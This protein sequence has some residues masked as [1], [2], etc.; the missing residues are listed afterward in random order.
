MTRRDWALAVVLLV[1]AVLVHAAFPRYEWH[2]LGGTAYVRFDRWTGY[3]D[4]RGYARPQGEAPRPAADQG[5]SLTLPAFVA[6]LALGGLVLTLAWRH[7]HGVHGRVQRAYR[8][9]LGWRYRWPSLLVVAGGVLVLVVYA[10]LDLR[11]IEE[12]RV[13]HSEP[14]S[15]DGAVADL[16]PMR[17][18]DPQAPLPGSEPFHTALRGWQLPGVIVLALAVGL[19]GGLVIG[20]LRGPSRRP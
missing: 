2:A 15:L 1:G 12:L 3:A 4:A 20:R 19:V 18:I 10:S 17:G 7:R 9:V 6:A 11:G 14:F 8:A 16:R 13:I 5:R